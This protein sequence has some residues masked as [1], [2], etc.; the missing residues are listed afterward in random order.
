MLYQV[1]DV[2]KSGLLLMDRQVLCCQMDL[3]VLELQVWN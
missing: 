3:S 2:F 1:M